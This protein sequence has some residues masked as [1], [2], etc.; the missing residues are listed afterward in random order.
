MY[1]QQKMK[2]AGVIFLLFLTL[3]AGAKQKKHKKK[4]KTTSGIVSIE[5]RRTACFG[6]CPDYS[7]EVNKD[8]T[9]TYTARMFNE[10]TGTFTKKIGTKKALEILAQ[11]EA[12]RIDTCRDVYE[13]RMQDLPGIV[14]NVHYKD[15]TKMIRNANFGPVFLTKMAKDP[16]DG[17]VGKKT[18]GSWTKIS[19]HG[20]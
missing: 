14:Y 7:I 5:M 6:R 4:S 12:M 10:D 15:S 9:A 16:M 17:L 18:D 19:N 13:S 11:Y 2:Q 3:S 8:G 1:K 20:K